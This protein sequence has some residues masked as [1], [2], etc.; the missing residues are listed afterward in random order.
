M[1]VNKKIT[2]GQL[3]FTVIYLLFWPTLFLFLSGDWFWT[4]GWI[5]GIWF[6]IT[7]TTI[8]LYMYFKDPSLLAERFRKPGTGSQKTWDKI[9]FNLITI[10]F[11]S[12]NIVIPLDSLRFRWTV[13]FPAMLKYVGCI[14]LLLSSFFLY[15]SFSDNT[16]LSP[17]IRVQTERQQKLVTTGVYG[18]V[19]HPMYLGGLLMFIGAPLLMGSYYGI[20]I[21]FLVVIL[22]AIRTLGEEKMLIEELEGY[23]KYKHKVKYRFL[24]FIW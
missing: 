13:D 18:F 17:L 8:M 14:L 10:F 11:L 5:F 4:E 24:P 12:W 6:L 2:T 19:R 16:F 20:G 9:F 7:C 23:E 3:I 15:R 22:L 21:G 1:E